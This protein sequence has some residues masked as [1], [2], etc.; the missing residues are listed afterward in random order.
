MHRC[1]FERRVIDPGAEEPGVETGFL[2]PRAKELHTRCNTI[3]EGCVLEVLAEL[4]EAALGRVQIAY[5]LGPE[6]VSIQF[7]IL[8]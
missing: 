1:N 2:V 3:R 8:V 6:A 5:I 7:T 4:L